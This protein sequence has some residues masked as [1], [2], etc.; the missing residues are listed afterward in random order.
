MRKPVILTID[1]DLEVLSAIERDLK[2]HYGEQ[3]RV[4]RADSGK[5]ALDLLRRLQRRNDAVALLVVDHRM[6]QNERCR[7]PPG[8]D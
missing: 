2:R 1:D 6:P 5:G 3:Y 4:L 8:S 7:N